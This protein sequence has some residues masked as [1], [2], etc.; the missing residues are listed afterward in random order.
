MVQPSTDGESTLGRAVEVQSVMD[1]KYKELIKK[2]LETTKITKL[3]SV[4]SAK[5]PE[6]MWVCDIIQNGKKPWIEKTDKWPSQYHCVQKDGVFYVVYRVYDENIYAVFR[7]RLDAIESHLQ[8]GQKQ[9][10]QFE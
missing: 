9:A 6:D 10:I 5:Y 2:T 4:L 1:K 7:E 8:S 3:D